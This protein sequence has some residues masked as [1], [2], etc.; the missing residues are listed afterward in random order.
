MWLID[1]DSQPATLVEN[2]KRGQGMRIIGVIVTTIALAI[3][4]TAIAG[5]R[6]NASATSVHSASASRLGVGSL[7]ERR[8]RSN[9]RARCLYSFRRQVRRGAQREVPSAR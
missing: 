8:F 9:R 1:F 5:A 2:H 4:V 3:T 6:V 7:H